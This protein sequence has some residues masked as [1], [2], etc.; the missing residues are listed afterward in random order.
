MDLAQI[1]RA[2][3]PSWLNYGLWFMAEAA[4]V[5]TDIGQL[6]SSFC[7][8]TLVAHRFS[9]HWNNHRHKHP[10]F[11]DTINGWLCFSYSRYTFH[12]LILPTR[13][14]IERS[15]S[16]RTLHLS[17]CT[18]RVY[19]LLYRAFPHHGNYNQARNGWLSSIKRDL[20]IQWVSL[21]SYALQIS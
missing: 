13:W 5:C 3:L 8:Y 18:W 9:G 12:T 14:I 2:Q 21:L 11:Q 4:I 17:I 6:S 19:L 20:R 10:H 15:S 1:N 7:S 16:V